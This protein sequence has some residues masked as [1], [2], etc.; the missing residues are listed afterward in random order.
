MNTFYE[1]FQPIACYFHTDLK[2]EEK[3]AQLHGFLTDQKKT[4]LAATGAI[5]AGYDFPDI[6]LVIHWEGAWGITDF[7]QESGRLGHQ[8]GYQGWSYCLIT[9]RER[10]PNPRDSMDRALFRDY[11]NKTI[12]RRHLIHLT[13][14]QKAIEKCTSSDL[15]CDLCMARSQ[16]HDQVTRVA[17]AV[18]NMHQGRGDRLLAIYQAF[19]KQYCL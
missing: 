10:A 12:C 17:K 6:Q 14:D 1:V 2:E 18:V 19:N 15:L 3:Q 16:A 5:G 11:L 4:I 13:F 9:P 8:P 7:L